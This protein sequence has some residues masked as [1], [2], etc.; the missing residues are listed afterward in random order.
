MITD[1]EILKTFKWRTRRK[2]KKYMKLKKSYGK[3][4]K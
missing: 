4:E 2:I 3:V 1:K